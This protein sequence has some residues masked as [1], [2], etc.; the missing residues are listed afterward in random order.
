MLW[1]S[2]LDGGEG[3]EVDR[4]EVLARDQLEA[5]PDGFNFGQ[6]RHALHV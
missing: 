6:F 5:F 3:G 2:G 4:D 1:P